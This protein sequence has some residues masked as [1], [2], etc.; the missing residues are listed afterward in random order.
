MLAFQTLVLGR[1]DLRLNAADH[2][3]RDLVLNREDVVERPVVAL[4]PEVSAR[5]CFDQLSG[6]PDAVA[7]LPHAAFK[8]V[9]HSQLAPDLA[10]IDVSALVGEARVARNHEQP[11]K[12]RETGKDIFRDPVGEVP[13]LGVAAAAL[14]QERVA[15]RVNKNFTA[16]AAD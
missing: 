8:D 5:L 13:L 7:A 2:A 1:I 11:A 12:A 3:V 4:R 9:A 16:A 15:G 14:S 6:D 10:D